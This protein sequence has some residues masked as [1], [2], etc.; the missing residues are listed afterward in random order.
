MPD[1]EAESNDVGPLCS[2]APRQ[3]LREAALHHAPHLARLLVV[4]S[5][6]GLVLYFAY[7]YSHSRL[8][9]DSDA[10]A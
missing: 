5:V 3:T 7:G 6:I 8:R 1:T 9:R 10:G 2:A 4:N